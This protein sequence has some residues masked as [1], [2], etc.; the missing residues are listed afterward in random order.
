MKDDLFWPLVRTFAA[1]S[2][3]SIG[4]AT[5]ITPEIHRRVVEQA[6]WMNDATFANLFAI[7]QAA[8]GPN[9]LII[10]LIGWHIDGPTGLAATTLAALIP[11]CLL[12]FAAGRMVKRV[13]HTRWFAILQAAL[14]PVTVGLLLA[15]GVVMARAAVDGVLLALVAAAA[16][17]LVF[18]TNRSPLWALA[19]GM[20]VAG[21]SYAFR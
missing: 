2:M 1:I 20:C 12:A 21:A 6:H 18:T 3:V 17:I 4:G 15:S 13:A 16:A 10:S 5:A 11:S 14:V 19:F 7:S 9:F 8:P